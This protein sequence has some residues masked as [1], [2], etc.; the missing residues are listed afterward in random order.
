MLELRCSECLLEFP[1]SRKIPWCDCGGLFD[2]VFEPSAFALDQTEYSLWRYQEML[3]VR[4]RVSVGE[5]ITPVAQIKVFGRR[6]DAKLDFLFPTGSFKDRGAAVFVSA[7][8]EAGVTGFIEDSSGNAGASMATYAARAGIACEVYC[9]ASASGPKLAQIERSGAVIH[10][11]AG[12]RKCASD[13]LAER[14]GTEFYA[15]HNWHP[16]FLHGTKTLAYEIAE[17]YDWNPPTHIVSPAG[18][19][20]VILGLQLGFE[21]LQKLGWI[22]SIPLLYAIQAESCAP[23]VYKNVEPEASLAE[24]IL[25]PNPPRLERLRS[26]VAGAATVKEH[27]IER[28]FVALARQGVHV[29]PTTAVLYYG[30]EQ[31]SI[32]TDEPVLVILTGSGLK[33]RTDF[34]SA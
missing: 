32:P 10:K 23:L 16:L 27:E 14:V 4:T 11:I 21:E 7:L 30:V 31:L 12:P 20:A 22:S 8:K 18:G 26:A 9:P 1:L 34:G 33:S 24:G 19:G 28:G 15:S 29:E 5:P 13:A 2:L 25:S 3:P 17:Q 6:V